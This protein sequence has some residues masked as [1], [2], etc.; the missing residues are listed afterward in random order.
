MIFQQNTKKNP[1]NYTT[2]MTIT[3][4]STHFPKQNLLITL[5]PIS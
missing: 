1:S 4:T 2:T 5:I 3:I